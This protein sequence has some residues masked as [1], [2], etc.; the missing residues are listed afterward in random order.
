MEDSNIISLLSTDARAAIEA[1]LPKYGAALQGVIYKIVGSQEVTEEVL[2]DTF[3]KVWK[4]AKS[5]NPSKG[6]LFTWLL[7]IARNTAIDRIRSKKFKLH[8]RSKSL[9]ATV[10]DHI[11][12]SE[13]MQIQDSGLQNVLHQLDEKYTQVIDILYFKGY[14]QQEAAK[15]LDISLGTVKSRVKIAMRELRKMLSSSDLTTV[16]ILQAII[17]Y[18][19]ACLEYYLPVNQYFPNLTLKIIARLSR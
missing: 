2:Q 19:R 9:D 16:L 10:Y 14:T 18:L 11:A 13:E 12:H 6:R 1:I 3:V 15:E 8:Q 7:N 5:Y 4:N 17:E